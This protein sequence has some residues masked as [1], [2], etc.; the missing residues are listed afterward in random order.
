MLF[1]EG[2]RRRESSLSVCPEAAE[3]LISNG[4]PGVF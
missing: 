2:Y 4:C 1:W 3:V